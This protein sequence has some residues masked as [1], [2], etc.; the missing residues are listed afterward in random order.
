MRG[1]YIF[2]TAGVLD[3]AQITALG[4]LQFESN[5]SASGP[6]T[7]STGAP[8]ASAGCTFT[9][10]TDSAGGSIAENVGHGIW[11]IT[12]SFC[13]S[14][15]CSPNGTLSFIVAVEHGAQDARLMLTS[16]TTD[17]L[18]CGD[19]LDFGLTLA[20]DLAKSITP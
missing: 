19:S 4:S 18:I 20:G 2:Q 16:F 15:S 5:G 11:S 7:F 10:S 6:V 1:N 3:F 13:P 8:T 17:Q 14:S 12:L 9:L